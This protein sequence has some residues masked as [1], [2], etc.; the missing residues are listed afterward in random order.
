[1]HIEVSASDSVQVALATQQGAYE[2][3]LTFWQT[4]RIFWRSTLWIMY[5]QLV[6]FGF[7]IDGVIAG[8][9]LS[10]PRFR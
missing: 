4:L 6:V 5:G 3:S 10:V 1:M 7:G 2:K 8:Y 9:L